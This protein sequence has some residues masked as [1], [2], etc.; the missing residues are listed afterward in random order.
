VRPLAWAAGAWVAITALS[1]IA[2]TDP[3]RGL[4]AQVGGEGGGLILVLV[5]AVVVLAGAGSSTGLRERARRWFVLT[6]MAIGVF[7]IIIRL[8]PGTFLTIGRLS[9]V[10]ATMGNQLFAG[11]LLA[12][13]IVA[14]MGDREQPLSRQL[15]VVGLLALATATF[16]ERSAI[17]LP[18]LGTVIFLARARMPARRAAALAV[19]VLAVLGAWQIAA[20]HL[21]TGGRGASLTVASQ[22]TDAQRFTVWRVLVTRAVPDRPILGWG[23]GSTQ[24]AYLANATEA[25]VR[26]T[27][28]GW[29][30]AHDL[31]LETLVTTG[32]LG[33]LALVAVLALAG[34]R[35]LRGSP[36]HAW[37]LG[38]AAALGGYAL[39]EPMNLVLTPLLFFFLAMAGR[40]EAEPEPGPEAGSEPAGR[41]AGAPGLSR[42]LRAVGGL[43]L[44]AAL[45]VS[46][47]MFAGAT[48]ERWGQ[49]YGEEWAY[50]DALRVQPWRV[51]ATEQ[52]AT[53]LAVDGRSHQAGAAAEAR[54]L[55]AEAVRAHPW[56]VNL[57][58]RAAD[59]DTLL[60]DPVGSHDWL[61]QQIQ[62][63]PGDAAGLATAA[64]PTPGP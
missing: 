33:L 42:A 56:D 43:M 48:L 27:T 51:S 37:A 30:D 61:Q 7:G 21:P 24:S 25:Q 50:R 6:C 3:S 22:A 44:A 59:I 17:V 2:G 16:G 15:P 53:Q 47:L 31:P 39:F 58:P 8:A 46:L 32:V 10:G 5:C 36:E 35:A 62:R 64:E 19:C 13:G 60:D 41:A 34:G 57:R 4:T 14:A 11:A 9:F 38:A 20:A 55:I 1:A 45:A 54:T 40:P 63:F 52:L 23:P 29:A 28:R 12:A 49:D 18:V 26:S